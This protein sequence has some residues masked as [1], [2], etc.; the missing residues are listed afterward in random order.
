MPESVG[1]ALDAG[2]LRVS[3]LTTERQPSYVHDTLSSL[4]GSSASVAALGSIELMIDADEASGYL[5]EFRGDPMLKLHYLSD[6]EWKTQSKR[7]LGHRF[8]YNYWRSLN[9]TMDRYWGLVVLEDDVLLREAFVEKLILTVEEVRRRQGIER[10][11]PKG[12]QQFM[13]ALYS[14][15]DFA[16]E[17]GFYRGHYY[18]S[19][20]YPFYGTCGMFY[21]A[22]IVG[23]VRDYMW[24]FGVENHRLPGDLLLDELKASGT[25]WLYACTRDLVQHVG[26]VSSGLGAGGAVFRSRTFERPWEPVHRREWAMA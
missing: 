7:R 15:Y 9:V 17:P 23:V 1:T 22:S 2:G 13:L 8:C 24:R 18:C 16:Q 25:L 5:R 11:G 19:Y 14:T 4:L 20:G 3:I 6:E 21:E 10:V 12:L 26:I